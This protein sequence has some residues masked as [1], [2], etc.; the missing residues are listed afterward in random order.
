MHTRTFGERAWPRFPALLTAL[1]MS[2]AT[3][4]AAPPLRACA[5]P[6]NLPFASSTGNQKGIYL[7]LADHLASALGRTPQPVW[8]LTYF[9]KRAVRNTL[10]AKECDL[11]IGLPADGDFMGKQVVM[12]KPFAVFRYA[13]VLPPNT[14]AQ[15]LADLRGR[16]VA[17][18]LSSPPQNLLAVVDGIE[19]VT[20]RSPEEGMRALSEGKADVAYLWGPSAGYLN[21][22]TYG[23]RYQ[24]IP[25]DGKAM[26]WPVAIGF[27][28]ADN[29][30]REHVQRELDTLGPWLGE[31]GVK[32]GFPNSAPVNLAS[33]PDKPIQLAAAGTLNGVL[34]QK[35]VPGKTAPAS[36]PAQVA[37]GKALFNSHC[38]HCHGP[39]AASPDPKIDLRKLSKRYRE[40]MDEVFMT[41][42]HDGRPDKGMPTW[43]GVIS[44][45]EIAAIKAFI[46]SVQ[47]SS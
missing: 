32:Y 15:S 19:T 45:D 33:T 5:D 14:R 16:R 20:V 18:Q 35:E 26:S 39:N 36:D 13:L 11:F 25:T 4:A 46:D 17:V 12:S 43:K 21:K 37:R 30:L 9:G 6:D 31:L 28:R 27:R 23:G 42:V 38:A 7:E 44:E 2:G 8:H 3:F 29:A 10:L 41:T 40:K 24:V 22:Y 34:A 47:P 1:L